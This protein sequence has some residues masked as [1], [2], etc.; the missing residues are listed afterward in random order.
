MDG[1]ALAPSGAAACDSRFVTPAADLPARR[2]NGGIGDTQSDISI[3]L[4][5]CQTGLPVFMAGYR[6]AWGRPANRHIRPRMSLRQS[7]PTG[8]CEQR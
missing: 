3:R 2:M 6:A 8:D 7:N 1:C 5:A 4:C